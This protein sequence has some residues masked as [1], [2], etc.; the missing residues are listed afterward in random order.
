MALCVYIHLYKQS[1]EY[2]LLERIIY[3]CHGSKHIVQACS[4]HKHS[5]CFCF[6]SK[7]LVLQVVICFQIFTPLKT[8]STHSI[9]VLI[10]SKFSDLLFPVPQ[11]QGNVLTPS[12]YFL[13]IVFTPLTLLVFPPKN[14]PLGR[15]KGCFSLLGFN[16]R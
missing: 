3:F 2:L 5:F 13:L 15:R 11:N 7:I 14:V 8:L 12:S 16:L 6:P 4:I 1:Y 9:F 10:S